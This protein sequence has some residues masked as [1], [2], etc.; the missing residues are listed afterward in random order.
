MSLFTQ[1]KND[2]NVIISWG[3]SVIISSGKNDQLVI[4][5]CGKN[6]QFFPGKMGENPHFFS[7]KNGGNPHFFLEGKSPL[8][9]LLR[10][11]SWV[12]GA[13]TSQLPL[14]HNQHLLH[15]VSRCHIPTRLAPRGA[16]PNQPIL[17]LNNESE[18]YYITI[19]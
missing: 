15:D 14:S 11:V 2:P 6:D 9:Q 17:L 1:V 5:S 18:Q 8:F 16:Q 13:I 4:I 7:W 19:G 12:L 3:K 10:V